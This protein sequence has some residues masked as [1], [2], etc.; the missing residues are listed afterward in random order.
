MKK[1]TIEDIEEIE[2]SLEEQR[3]LPMR[4][5]QIKRL[6]ADNRRLRDALNKLAGQATEATS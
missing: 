5:H 6:I 2:R 3:N 1:L 4:R